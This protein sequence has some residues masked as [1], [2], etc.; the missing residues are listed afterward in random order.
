MLQTIVEYADSAALGMGDCADPVSRIAH[1]KIPF[2]II[3]FSFL[4]I[5]FTEII[6]KDQCKST[7]K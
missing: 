5:G 3:L 1:L 2:N 4:Y 7:P 6:E